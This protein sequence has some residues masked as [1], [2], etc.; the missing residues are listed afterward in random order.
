MGAL[1]AALKAADLMAAKISAAARASLQVLGI[2]RPRLR[3]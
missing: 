3:G 1:A 2:S